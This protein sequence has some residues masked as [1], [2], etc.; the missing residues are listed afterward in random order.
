MR[1]ELL[2]EVVGLLAVAPGHLPLALSS[3]GGLLSLLLVLLRLAGVHVG[4]LA[5]AASLFAQAFPFPFALGMALARGH[6]SED[7]QNDDD[8]DY[9][10]DQ[11]G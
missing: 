2:L 11:S 5:V 1:L 10:D 8:N 6:R 7:E 3:L 4:Y 9:G